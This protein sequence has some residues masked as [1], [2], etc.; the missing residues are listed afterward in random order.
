MGAKPQ[1]CYNRFCAIN[2]HVITR[3]QCKWRSSNQRRIEDNSTRGEQM[4]LKLF[5]ESMNGGAGSN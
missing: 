2:D 3:Q 1:P 4:H 5:L